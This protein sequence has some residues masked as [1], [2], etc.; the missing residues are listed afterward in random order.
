MAITAFW[1]IEAVYQQSFA[2][3]LEDGSETPKELRETCQRWGNDSFA[4]YCLSLQKIAEQN[5]E[6]ASGDVM[7]KAE[8]VFLSVLELETEFW[9]MSQGDS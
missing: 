6:K 9:N 2:H 4:Q 3:C 7:A 5:L 8:S 1:A